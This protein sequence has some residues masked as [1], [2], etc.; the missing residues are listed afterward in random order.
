MEKKAQ[1]QLK[2]LRRL[3]PWNWDSRVEEHPP[4]EKAMHDFEDIVNYRIDGRK[5]RSHSI[6]GQSIVKAEKEEP[7]AVCGN[8][9]KNEEEGLV[10]QQGIQVQEDVLFVE[11]VVDAVGGTDDDKEN[12]IP[13]DSIEEVEIEMKEAEMVTAKA[14][15]REMEGEKHGGADQKMDALSSALAAV[16]AANDRVARIKITSG[17]DKSEDNVSKEK[18]FGSPVACESKVAGGL[19]EVETP[20]VCWSGKGDGKKKKR[21]HDACVTPAV[22][23]VDSQFVLTP[24][25]SSASQK[26][27]SLTK[28]V[29]HG[30]AM[31]NNNKRTQ[32][33]DSVIGAR[34]G[35]RGKQEH[36]VVEPP[37]QTEMGK[38]SPETEKNES[39]QSLRNVTF[40]AETKRRD[41]RKKDGVI[42]LDDDVEI[43]LDKYGDG[44]KVM[45][46]ADCPPLFSSDKV[47]TGSIPQHA[48]KP[49]DEWY[50]DL[51]SPRDGA[52]QPR[53]ATPFKGKGTA[54]F[55]DKEKV[56]K[57]IIQEGIN[58]RSQSLNSAS[59]PPVQPLHT[60]SK[61]SVLGSRL[62]WA[63]GQLAS[64][65]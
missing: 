51:Q 29:G 37:M 46:P 39:L 47:S 14:R 10:G 41:G 54:A 4:G 21:L 19:V 30:D 59:L 56:I 17:S 40:S 53:D 5:R 2:E 24:G 11:P 20:G 26:P 43:D 45:R 63:L 62:S 25:S 35:K 32:L 1:R 8:A 15:T 18:V 57:N 34:R 64:Q 12:M 48:S 44:P 13:S 65:S 31:R 3:M 9:K 23:I 60:T 6:V 49:R 50:K 36:V 27:V 33:P 38:P 22:A 61:L 58:L 42:M 55:F 52:V 16:Q 28:D 7:L